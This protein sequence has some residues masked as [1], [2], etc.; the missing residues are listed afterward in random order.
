V[1]GARRVRKQQ[2]D[3]ETLIFT[4]RCQE[5]LQDFDFRL[6]LKLFSGALP[7]AKKLVDY[8]NQRGKRNSFYK[9]WTGSEKCSAGDKENSEFSANSNESQ[10]L[11]MIE[12]LL[13]A[14][15]TMKNRHYSRKL[16][17][18]YFEILKPKFVL[19]LDFGNFKHCSAKFPSTAYESL[20]KSCRSNFIIF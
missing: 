6:Y 1:L 5:I 3:G 10:L 15:S 14:G 8:E 11:I 16:T 13:I 12:K 9:F 18:R 19:L 7:Q 20:L 4:G 2:W 17:I